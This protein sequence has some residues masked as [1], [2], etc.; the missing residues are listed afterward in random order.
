MQS[1]QDIVYMQ[2]CL[3]NASK[4]YEAARLCLGQCGA[5][6]RVVAQAALH[7]HLCPPLPPPTSQ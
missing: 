2:E 1:I 5:I 4:W 3:N 6:Q 7:P